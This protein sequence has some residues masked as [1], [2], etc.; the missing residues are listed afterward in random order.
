VRTVTM[1]L[2]VAEE[3]RAQVDDW[4]DQ[5]VERIEHWE[6]ELARL[7]R[8]GHRHHNR[9]EIGVARRHIDDDRREVKQLDGQIPELDAKVEQCRHDEAQ[10]DEP[11]A[12]SATLNR[13]YSTVCYQLNRDVEH[14]ADKIR[15]S[16]SI[17][18][19]LGPRPHDGR[20]GDRWDLAAF[21]RNPAHEH[22]QLE[23]QRRVT[24]AVRS[25]DHVRERDRSLDRG[26]G[27]E[28]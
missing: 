5:A 25:L 3:K 13:E 2:A 6:T 24:E 21:S 23:H 9:F 4:R 28:M 1:C 7:D 14:R 8:F 10:L 12:T 18:E 20:S 16:P 17:I 27:I 19:A 26:Y 22:L 15:D 11:R